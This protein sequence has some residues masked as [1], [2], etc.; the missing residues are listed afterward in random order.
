MKKRLKY[1]M[2]RVR[3]CQHRPELQQEDISGF[4][5]DNHIGYFTSCIS[6]SSKCNITVYNSTFTM[7]TGSVISLSNSSFV[8]VSSSFFNNSTPSKGGAINSYNSTLH[9]SDSGFYHNEALVG[10]GLCLEFSTATVSNSTFVKNSAVGGGAAF[11]MQNSSLVISHSF[12]ESVYDLNYTF[13]NGGGSIFSGGSSLLI[14][15]T[16]FE[17]SVATSFCGAICSVANS[18][19]VIEDSQFQNNS[20]QDKAVGKGGSLCIGKNSSAKLSNVY[21]FGNNALAGGAI[22]AFDF[23]H[24]TIYN[25][26]IEANTGSAIAF[27]NNVHSKIYISSFFDNLASYKGG[28]AIVSKAGCILHVTKTLFKANKAIGSGGVFF[29]EGILSFFHNCSFIDNF[30]FKGGVLAAANSNVELFTSNFMNN[31]ATEGGTDGSLLLDHCRFSN[32]TAYG[33]GGVGYIEENSQIKITRNVFR[34]NSATHAGG[35]LWLRK[36]VVNITDSVFVSNWAGID[37]GV[38]DAQFSSLINISHITCFENKNKGGEGGVLSVRRKTKVWINHA[39]IQNNSAYRCGVMV[40]DMASVFEISNSLVSGNSA[41]SEAGAF[42]SFNNSLSVFIN[43]SFRGNVGYRAGSIVIVDS[44]TYL[45]NCTLRGNQGTIAGAITIA[46]SDLKLSNTVFLANKAKVAGD[47]NCET[48]ETKFI[49][50]LY[51][52]R[53]KFKRGNVTIRSDVIDFKHIADQKHFMVAYETD[54]TKIME[55]QFASSKSFL[56]L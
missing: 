41:D 48:S 26:T 23:C 44:I 28:G 27:Y 21:F 13:S 20:V 12:S 40:I 22:Y 9:I 55:T 5:C 17:S 49:N 3:L 25:N 50:I 47:I 14:F 42:C 18:S 8:I 33:N 56:S 38:I 45:E 2:P 34:F 36:A 53:S 32:N 7:N 4:N 31:S 54:K 29:G 30:A 24:I 39:K 37:G 15:G 6:A 51:T 52:Y 1:V 16:V 19:I 10:G 11:V 43:S 35:V 46:S